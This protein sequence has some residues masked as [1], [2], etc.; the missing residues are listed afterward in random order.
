VNINEKN[1]FYT[2]TSKG[3]K[4]K[5]NSRN[6]KGLETRKRILKSS[7]L[8]KLKKGERMDKKL[9][10]RLNET[11]TTIDE[12]LEIVKTQVN[13]KYSFNILTI[14]IYS[15]VLEG[16]GS[17]KSDF[18]I[19][20]IVEDSDKS[21]MINHVIES[22]KGEIPFDIEIY[23][24]TR[25]LQLVEESNNIKQEKLLTLKMI[26]KFLKAESIFAH[27]VAHKYDSLINIEKIK[28]IAEDFFYQGTL[29]LKDDS[30]YMFD[31]GDYESALI[32]GREALQQ[33]IAYLNIVKG[34]LNFK[35]KWIYRLFVNNRGYETGFLEKYRDLCLYNTVNERNVKNY[36][37]D[38]HNFIQDILSYVIFM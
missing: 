14:K 7:L 22:Y 18:D 33:A 24:N 2:Q 11:H 6:A 3:N 21:S 13:R 35:R 29:N 16:L 30:I 36:V 9:I 31:M 27:E 20:V 19:Y 10:D 23:S 32:L 34:N 5:N 15:S 26:T 25:F 28:I 1:L 37:S 8:N 12:I 4:R 38:M 17:L